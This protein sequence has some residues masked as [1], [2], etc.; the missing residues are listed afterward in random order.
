MVDLIRLL[1]LLCVGG[2]AYERAKAE[3]TWSWKLFFLALLGIAAICGASIPLLIISGY[4]LHAGHTIAG[5]FGIVGAA[6]LMISGIVLL[7]I[8]TKPRKTR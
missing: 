2:Q 1:M 5:S 6:L 3:G 8:W 4:T 7:A